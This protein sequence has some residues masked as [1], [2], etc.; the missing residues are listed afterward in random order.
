MLTLGRRRLEE[1]TPEN[2]EN[3]ISRPHTIN[4]GARGGHVHFP[5]NSVVIAG[6]LRFSKNRITLTMARNDIFIHFLQPDLLK[7]V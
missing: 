5:A 2:L 3:M 4:R 1:L 7:I 6:K